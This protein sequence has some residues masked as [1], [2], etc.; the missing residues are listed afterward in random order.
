MM[1]KK[2]FYVPITSALVMNSFAVL[3]QETPKQPNIIFIMSDDHASKA[4]SC[5]D[6]SINQTPNIDRI[7][8]NGVQFSNCFATNALSGPSRACI[9]T[10]KL[11]HKNGMINNDV[12][13][14]SAQVT[15][16]KLLQN[17]GYQT[18]IVGKWHLKSVPS[19]FQFYSVLPGQGEYFNPDFIQNG[20]KIREEG[21]VTDIITDKSL[22]WIDQR[23]T[24]KPFFIM[25]HQK[26]PHRPW[27]PKLE[28]ITLYDTAQIPLPDNF[29][30]DYKTRSRA[31]YE[32]KMT[33][34]DHLNPYYD[35][36]ISDSTTFESNYFTDFNRLSPSERAIWDSIYILRNQILTD[37][38]LTE[39]ELDYWKY[40][41]FLNDYLATIKS[42]DDNVGRVLDYLKEH[43]LEENTIVVYTS[44]QGFF[45][46][47]HGWYD[48]RFMYDESAQMPLLIQYPEK[49]EKESTCDQ[50]VMNID[51]APTL[52]DWAGIE[53]PQEMQG[54]SFAN[55][56][57]D[58]IL[59]REAVYY[60]YFEFP[61]EHQVKR[62][63][64]IRTKDFKLIHFYDDIDV[65]ELYDL[66]RDPDEMNN[67]FNQL[68]YV[69]IQNELI[70][71]LKELQVLYEDTNYTR[72]TETL[73][74][75]NLILNSTYFIQKPK[76]I[77]YLGKSDYPLTDG[78]IEN[79][80]VTTAYA[81]RAWVGLEG[82]DLDVRL[83]VP[84]GGSYK[85][86]EIRFLDLAES[87]IFQPQKVEVYLYYKNQKTP[88]IVELPFVLAE[89]PTGGYLVV[90]Q[91]N[92]EQKE[93]V[94]FEVKAKN[95]GVCPEG[96]PGAGKPAWL[97]VDEIMVY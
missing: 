10:G 65:W 24:S 14:D 30:D 96:H 84:N 78:L 40:R 15:L 41:R 6:G 13:F 43:N 85:T 72:E 25:I 33:I 77:R 64:G 63:Y 55:Y 60:H 27:L 5:Y 1:C 12:G 23:D 7:A 70:V 79:P 2:K 26:A 57:D 76:G 9:L 93:L 91:A 92:I 11:N 73:T 94:R 54:A 21:Y 47:E 22:E 86:I 4:I 49:I 83:D 90:Y 53:I 82:R 42:V 31:V 87:W 56:L 8:Q 39:Q 71:Q 69:P 44:D 36:K 50:M 20:T 67:V 35:L 95:Q 16:P 32:Q 17:N 52:L 19:G 66:T 61:G 58:Q 74:I 89:R 48:K 81:K 51:F 34:V 62:H 45:L 88:K 46:G 68:E 37:S 28:N 97:F 38:N 3:A 18:A 75:Q 29:Y 59:L 80:G